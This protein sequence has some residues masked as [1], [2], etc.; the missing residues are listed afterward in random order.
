MEALRAALRANGVKYRVSKNTLARIAADE[1][2]RPEIK[3]VIN[4]PC[5][6]VVGVGDPAAAAK[7]LVDHVKGNRVNLKI[8]GGVLQG[9]VISSTAVVD[10]ANLPSR[11]VLLS[12]LLGQMN[13]PITGL[14]IV[15]SGPARSLAIVLKRRAEQL[16]CAPVAA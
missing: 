9:R 11:E 2:G 4:G 12:R 15:L 1:V 3:E 14:V 6:F 7:A 16:E 10:L 5:G 13:A 8:L